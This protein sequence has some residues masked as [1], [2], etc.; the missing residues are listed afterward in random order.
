M[1]ICKYCGDEIEFRYVDGQT[2]PIH[3]NG[4]WCTGYPSAQEQ[5]SPKPFGSVLSYVD[6]NAH[7]PVCGHVVFFYQSP[8]GG[9]VF[10]DDVGWPWP[11]HGCTDNPK[12]Q[13]G[14]VRSA[15]QLS[16]RPF[17]L[18]MTG[19]ALNLYRIVELTEESFSI[20]VKFSRIDK[21]LVAFRIS[22]PTA[23]LKESDITAKDLQNA[24]A[25][26]VRFRD[27]HR[28]LEFISGRK[29]QIESIKVPRVQPR[30]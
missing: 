24:P 23:L 11:K 17:F 26:V 4:G 10:F 27:D 5:R 14:S 9:R 15:D 13:T 3:I 16:H 29:K 12:S 30:L 1:P 20:S 21:P 28:L 18:S 19:E 7:C 22:I 25:F 6:P 8:Y 2:T